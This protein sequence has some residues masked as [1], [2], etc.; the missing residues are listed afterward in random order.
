MRKLK[1]KTFFTI[2][3]FLLVIQFLIVFLDV[4]LT[5]SESGLVS[6]TDGLIE[7]LSLPISLINKNLPFYV[8]ETLFIKALYW[9]MNLFIQ[10]SAI[11]LGIRVFKRV[12]KKLN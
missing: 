7:I 1:L 4:M 10:T 3:T 11:Y 2:F 9:L 6:V 5:K 12:R 8:R